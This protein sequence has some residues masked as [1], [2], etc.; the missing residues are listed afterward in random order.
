MAVMA[1]PQDQSPDITHPDGKGGALMSGVLRNCRSCRSNGEHA[2]VLRSIAL[3]GALARHQSWTNDRLSQQVG[4][5][6]VRSRR[7]L[8]P[9]RGIPGDQQRFDHRLAWG[10]GGIA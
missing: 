3:G 7:V 1:N 2:I 8:R 6:R 4:L 9:C 5:H 10:G